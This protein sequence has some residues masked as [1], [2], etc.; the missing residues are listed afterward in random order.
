VLLSLLTG[1]APPRPASPALAAPPA[2]FGGTYRIEDWQNLEGRGLYH[3]FYL[4]PGGRFLLAGAWP[5][6]ETSAFAGDWSVTGELLYLNGRGQVD[7]NQGRWQV[8]FHRTYRIQVRAEGFRLEP[9]PRKNRYGL[10]G[11]PNAFLFYRSR[12]VPNLPG[13]SLPDSEAALLDR[14]DRLAPRPR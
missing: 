10:M 2:K 1:A 13:G 12:P 3:F 4:H 9:V 11:W 5:G 8:D 14:I 7:T 6:H